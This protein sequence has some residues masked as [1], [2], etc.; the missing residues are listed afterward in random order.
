MLEWPDSY[1][2]RFICGEIA[3]IGQAAGWA[4]L[5][6]GPQC[7]IDTPSTRRTYFGGNPLPKSLDTILF[8][9]LQ[10]ILV[11]LVVVMTAV[12]IDCL[13]LCLFQANMTTS[14]DRDKIREAYEDVRSDNSETEW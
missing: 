9:A 8:Y 2:D 12:F 10:S 1:P 13:N 6:R 14:I 5:Y 7:E 4:S 11:F 3:S